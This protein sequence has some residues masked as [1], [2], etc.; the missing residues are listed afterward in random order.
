MLSTGKNALESVLKS[1]L[2]TACQFTLGENW[3]RDYVRNLHSEIVGKKPLDGE[4]NGGHAT[5]MA[6]S[7][8]SG[9]KPAVINS[10]GLGSA[11]GAYEI[12]KVQR[13]GSEWAPLD[14]FLGGAEQ[15]RLYF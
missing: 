10:G 6:T 13:T 1:K 14:A 15:C 12:G 7:E 2:E 3:S 5:R 4:Y 8:V 11:A 9:V